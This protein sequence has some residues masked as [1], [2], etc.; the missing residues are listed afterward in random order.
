[1]LVVAPAVEDQVQ[2]GLILAEMEV[3]VTAAHPMVLQVQ[4]EHPTQ[5]VVAV[6]VLTIMVWELLAVKVS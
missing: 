3:A 1:M 2:V 4:Q 5:V 6:L